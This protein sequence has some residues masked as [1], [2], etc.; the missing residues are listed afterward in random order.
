MFSVSK[1]K[2]SKAVDRNRIKR[3]LRENYRL[4]KPALFEA[5]P[6]ETYILLGILFTGKELPAFEDIQKSLNVALERL[7]TLI[8]KE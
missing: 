8:R 1:R 3:L 6:A 5:I 4:V 2:F 7:V